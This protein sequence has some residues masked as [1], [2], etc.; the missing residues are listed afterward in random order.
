MVQAD[1][2]QEA[3]DTF[4]KGMKGTMA[5]FEIEKVAE[6]K[7]IDIYPAKLSSTNGTGKAD[8]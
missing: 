2:Q 8:G 1:S 4:N 3:T 6:T 5:D 7:I